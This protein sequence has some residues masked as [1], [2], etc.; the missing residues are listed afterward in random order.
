[1]AKPRFPAIERSD[2][3]VFRFLISLFATIAD[4]AG[5]ASPR[6]KLKTGYASRMSVVSASVPIR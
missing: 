1:M 5:C 2:R 4:A 3:P 6:R